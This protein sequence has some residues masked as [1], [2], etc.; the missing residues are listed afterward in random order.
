MARHEIPTVVAR[1]AVLLIAGLLA[2]CS[3]GSTNPTAQTVDPETEI[4][5]A[6]SQL[7]AADQA[8]VEAQEWCVVNTEHRLGSMGKPVKLLI[9]GK[10]VFLC[11]ASCRK[12]AEA[13]PE[14]TLARVE[15]LKARKAGQPGS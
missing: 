10:A 13:N 12:K 7:N 6:R 2:G 5:E 15:E 3:S 9:Q 4:R 14:Q 1:S 11:C 8:L